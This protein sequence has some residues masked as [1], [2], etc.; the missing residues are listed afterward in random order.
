[1]S[2]TY[3]DARREC[4]RIRRKNRQRAGE[5]GSPLTVAASSLR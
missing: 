4:R 2:G 1:M 5:T 3:E